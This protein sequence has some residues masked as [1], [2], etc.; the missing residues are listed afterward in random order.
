MAVC[1][2][3]AAGEAITLYNT[4]AAVIAAIIIA[5][6]GIMLKIGYQKTDKIISILP[7]FL[8]LGSVVMAGALKEKDFPPETDAEYTV[9]QSF[10]SGENVRILTREG[11]LVYAKSSDLTGRLYRG[12]RIRVKGSVKELSEPGNPGQFDEKTYYRS[13]GISR[14]CMAE[15]VRLVSHTSN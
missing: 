13:L 8:L 11:L 4:S 9:T 10:D 14:K 1:I 12:D 7:V 6:T 5:I 15:R 2:A 3:F